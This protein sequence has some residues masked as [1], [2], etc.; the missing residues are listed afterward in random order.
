MEEIF[1]KIEVE[2]NKESSPF[3]RKPS[4]IT[5]ID[6]IYAAIL[7]GIASLIKE[8]D[9]YYNDP[10]YYSKDIDTID[11]EGISVEPNYPLNFTPVKRV[12]RKYDE[13]IDVTWAYP[14][15]QEEKLTNPYIIKHGN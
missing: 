14:I 5:D 12:L 11:L 10:S 7:Q 6:L 3:S 8:R 15:E 4:G 13:D 9:E 1:Y 2:P